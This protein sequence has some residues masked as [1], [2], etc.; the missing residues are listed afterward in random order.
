MYLFG[1]TGIGSSV[2]LTFPDISFLRYPGGNVAKAV[3]S[4]EGYA[5]ALEIEKNNKE[6]MFGNYIREDVYNSINVGEIDAFSEGGTTKTFDCFGYTDAPQGEG[7]EKTNGSNAIAIVNIEED[8][9]I[10]YVVTYDDEYNEIFDSYSDAVSFI[11]RKTEKYDKTESEIVDYAW[12]D[13]TK[14]YDIPVYDDITY[15]SCEDVDWTTNEDDVDEEIA[16]WG[17]DPIPF[18]RI[19]L[20][21]CF[22][23]FSFT[24]VPS[25]KGSLQPQVVIPGINIQITPGEI[26]VKLKPKDV[27]IVIGGNTWMNNPE[28]K[29]VEQAMRGGADEDYAGMLVELFQVEE[30]SS[31]E[32]GT[33]LK[34]TTTGE[35]GCYRFIKLKPLY[36]YYVRFR[37]NGQLYQANPLTDD[38]SGGYSN[39]SETVSPETRAVFNQKFQT[40]N[41]T[42]ANYGGKRAYPYKQ[43]ITKTDSKTFEEI[44]G[45]DDGKIPGSFR[46]TAINKRCSSK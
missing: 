30:G 12:N 3:G 36:D 11:E 28:N 18:R 37:Y 41:S 33:L 10:K 34:T 13:E 14:K 5:K 16:R 29:G 15:Y 1:G 19:E 35:N 7:G 2:E 25:G 6:N 27:S 21:P 4:F 26:E 31:N 40:I 39:A 44:W 38:L 32:G 8:K 43:K 42:P 22:K 20:S 9:T 17:E 23:K 46:F 45:G 24:F